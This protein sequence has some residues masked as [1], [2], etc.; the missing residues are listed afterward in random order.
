[1]TVQDIGFG[2]ASAQPLPAQKGPV[3]AARQRL[4]VHM[5]V[6]AYGQRGLAARLARQHRCRQCPQPGPRPARRE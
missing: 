5:P 3:T 1:M 6:Q 2:T 4:G